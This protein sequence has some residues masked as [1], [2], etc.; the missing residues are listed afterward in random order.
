MTGQQHNPNRREHRSSNGRFAEDPR[1]AERAA[2]AIDLRAQGRTYQQIAD[3]LGYADKGQAWRAVERG[4]LAI[5]KEPVERLIQTEAERLDEL[6]VEALEVL[7]REHVTVSHGKVVCD[8]TGTPILDDGPRLAA[9]DRL[10]KIRESYRKLHGL[11]AE[12]KVSVSGGVR[13]EVVGIDPADH[14]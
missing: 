1:T 9:L 10:V 11:D 5:L 8:E 7:S 3:E 13:Y 12:K 6:Y 14:T 4:K 2:A